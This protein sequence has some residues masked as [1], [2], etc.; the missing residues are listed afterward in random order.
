MK[1]FTY[2]SIYNL[3]S[4]NVV[5]DKRYKKVDGKYKI[6]KKYVYARFDIYN[7]FIT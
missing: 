2:L 6:Y 7:V 3:K 4:K 5:K 1:Y